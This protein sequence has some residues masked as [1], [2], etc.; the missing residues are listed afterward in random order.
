MRYQLDE[1]C[2][3]PS[4]LEQRERVG[5]RALAIVLTL[6][7]IMALSLWFAAAHAQTLSLT[8]D[9]TTSTNGQVIPALTW[10]TTPT[11][12]SCTASGDSTWTGA[13]AV[14]GTLTLPA[15][16]DPKAYTLGCTFPGQTSIGLRWTNPTT[17]TDGSAYS[18]AKGTLIAYGTSATALTSSRMVSQPTATTA[19]LTDLTPGTYFA[20]VKAVNA[21][22]MQSNCSNVI[23]FTLAAGTTITQTVSL[24]KPSPP[25]GLAVEQ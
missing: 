11:A 25:T 23:Q 2:P 10:S 3:T 14:S 13:K 24:K 5:H 16:S 7:A 6:V 20:C 1:H 19:T 4:E 8:L 9:T 18:N 15:T 22:D 17:N 12:A 21:T